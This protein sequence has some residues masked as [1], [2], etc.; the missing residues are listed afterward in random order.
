VSDEFFWAESEL[1]ITTGTRQYLEKLT[2]S[3]HFREFPTRLLHEDGSFDGEGVTSSMTWQSTAALGWISL[4]QVPSHLPEA[5][6]ARLRAALV[7]A[8]DFYLEVIEREGYRLPLGLG[9]NKKYPWGSNSFV[10][11]NMVVL[12]LSYDITHERKYAEGVVQGMDYLLGRNP[13]VQSYVTG[14]GSNPLTQP[15]HRFWANSKDS[16]FPKP[17]PGAVSGG[18]N[19]SLQDPQTRLSGLSKSLPPQKCFVDHIDAWSVN[20]VAINW[21][22]PLAW[23]AV[24]LNEWRGK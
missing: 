7:A 18:P 20:E 4:A 13:M 15:H 22:A 11:N 8:A 17:P 3:P 9:E 5:D 10:L 14:H 16:R 2:K 6:R 24:F 12:S 1:F 21:N 19:S 23:C